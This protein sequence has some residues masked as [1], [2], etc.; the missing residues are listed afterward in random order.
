MV[1]NPAIFCR[2][3]HDHFVLPCW[4]GSFPVLK[5]VFVDRPLNVLFIS[6]LGLK[7]KISGYLSSSYD[8]E[9]YS[10]LLHLPIS[11]VTLLESLIIY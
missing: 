3:F 6:G 8:P 1:I 4:E 7:S 2:A 10:L 11:R 9:K 5:K